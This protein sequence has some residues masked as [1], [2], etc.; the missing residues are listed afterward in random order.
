MNSYFE[1]I[2]ARVCTNYVQN[3][4]EKYVGIRLSPLDYRHIRATHHYHGV[5][6]SRSSPAEK[7]QL[8][9][10]YASSVGQ[11]AEIMKNHYVYFNP[12]QL[13]SQS[14]DNVAVSNNLLKTSY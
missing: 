14:F 10:N 1:D 7:A 8:I 2:S 5:M 12:E 13:A 6:N 4:S 9:E 11:S 3:L